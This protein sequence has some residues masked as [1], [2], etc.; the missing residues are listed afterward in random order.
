MTYSPEQSF[1]REMDQRD[2]LRHF[3][4][5]Y[6]FPRHAGA[7][8]LYFCGNSLGLQPKAA[9]AAVEEE[10]DRWQRLGVKGHFEGAQPWTTYHR[11]LTKASM[12]IVGAKEE[13]VVIMNTLTV[14][15][16]LLMVTFYR[17]NPKRFKILMEAGAFPSDQYAVE[18]Q[19]RHHGFDPADAILEIEPREGEHTL[20]TED[21]TAA[22]EEAGDSLALVLFSGLQYYTGQFFDIPSITRAAHAAGAYAGFDCAHAAGNVPLSMHEWGCDFALWCTYKYLNSGPGALGGVFI[23]ER[24]ARNTALPRFAGWWG[25]D[26][27]RRFLMEKG[28]SP[29]P[30]AEGWQL[31]NAPILSL[32]AMRPSH[33][34][35]LQAGMEALREKSVKLTGYLEFLVR[36]LQR[37][38]HPY[39]I[40]T[41]EEPAAR[42]CQLSLLTGPNGRALF[43]FISA[44]G[45]ICDWREPNVIRLAPAPMYNSFA[46]VHTLGQLLR[47]FGEESSR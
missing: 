33:D 34:L 43:D 8:C 31:S 1:A 16:H 24:H 15:L 2:P 19:V 42:G 5:Q 41:P 6:L 3:R 35:F 20:R 22:I 11:A 18:S 32:A 10:M 26:E 23:H 36:Q 25:H 45:V 7:D 12:A 17:P 27:E 14:N 13:E 40:I 44:H 37:A 46:D 28:F 30:T 4:S 38:G 29:I 39:Q 9:R 21:I 47:S